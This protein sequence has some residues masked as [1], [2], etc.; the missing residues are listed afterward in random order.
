MQYLEKV[1]KEKDEKMKVIQD[2]IAKNKIE[3]SALIIPTLIIT[4]PLVHHDDDNRS[5]FAVTIDQKTFT[6]IK[7]AYYKSE[8]PGSYRESTLSRDELEDLKK[9]YAKYF[10][11]MWQEF[12]RCIISK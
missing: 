9:F 6:P 8:G 11:D 10:N 1:H 4:I 7:A 3:N 5:G 12:T 2:F